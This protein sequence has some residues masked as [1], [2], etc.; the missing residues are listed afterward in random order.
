MP[1]PPPVLGR[2]QPQ[3]QIFGSHQQ[4]QQMP[5]GTQQQNQRL[6]PPSHI[7]IPQVTP[8]LPEPSACPQMFAPPPSPTTATFCTGKQRGKYPDPVD[9][10]K[11]I[12]CVAER[13]YR[14]R[15]SL[16]PHWTQHTAFVITRIK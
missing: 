5:F 2:M 15:V 11:F 8:Q 14:V 1:P 6:L 10:S 4:H 3:Q 16:V 13:D 7:D 9:C 12:E